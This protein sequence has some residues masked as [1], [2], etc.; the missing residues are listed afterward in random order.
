VAPAAARTIAAWAFDS[1]GLARVV[2]RAHVGNEASRRVAEK[3]G[4]VF[5]GTE[6]SGLDHRGTRR[7]A[8]VASLVATD[9]R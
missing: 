5:E 7:D 6:R 8:W 3:A 9:P 1:L 2:W 4:L